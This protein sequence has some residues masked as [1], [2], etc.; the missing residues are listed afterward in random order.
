MPWGSL[1]VGLVL[2]EPPVLAGLAALGREGAA[3]RLT[4]NCE[5]WE[6]NT[7]ADLASLPD[8][9]PEHVLGLADRYRAAGL[10][11]EAAEYLADDAVRAL[12]STWARKLLSSR[13]SARFLRVD[14]RRVEA[15][16]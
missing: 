1:L 8:A 11:V 9:T 3:Y 16:A 14:A 12:P 15:A 6:A 4:L 7:P 10:A 13:T 2:A 5:I